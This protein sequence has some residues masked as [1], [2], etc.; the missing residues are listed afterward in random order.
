MWLRSGYFYS[1]STTDS[2]L[3]PLSGDARRSAL[4]QRQK[5]LIIEIAF[6]RPIESSA[7]I[8]IGADVWKVTTLVPVGCARLSDTGRVS[9]WKEDNQNRSSQRRRR[10][11]PIRN[12]TRLRER[13]NAAEIN[14]IL[15]RP[16]LIGSQQKKKS[17]HR[18]RR[19]K[20]MFEIESCPCAGQS[21]I[22]D[23]L[24]AISTI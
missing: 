19:K 14:C 13:K 12:L 7:S 18:K 6:L 2:K 20:S 15:F 5:C 9:K 11:K 16:K 10:R 8:S 23:Y 3:S 24:F 4:L 17:E 1:I 22:D 21:M